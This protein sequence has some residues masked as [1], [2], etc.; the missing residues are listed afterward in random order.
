MFQRRK[1]EEGGVHPGQRVTG[2]PRCGGQAVG[3]PGEPGQ[4]GELFHRHRESDPV[5]P[6]A[7]EPEPR[8]ADLDDLLVEFA[9]LLVTQ[10]EVLHHPG[11]EVLHHHVGLGDHPAEK[12]SSFLGSEI[13][14]DRAFAR[15][16]AVEHPA[17][18]G[19]I[20][21]SATIGGY[22]PG[23]ITAVGEG[24]KPLLGL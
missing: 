14:C 13:K 1:G 8:H 2:T 11:G 7:V 15:I 5:A 12:C 22:K 16:D 9:Q 19:V 23:G 3:I 17:V 24:L 10:P 4:S 18:F 20:L 21:S 6:R